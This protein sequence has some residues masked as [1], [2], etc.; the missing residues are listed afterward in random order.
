M[1]KFYRNQNGSNHEK[2]VELPTTA[3]ETYKQGEALVLS[4]GALTKCG[5]TT[6]P[7]HIAGRDYAAPATGNKPLP[8][9]EI[10]EGYEL[11]TTL[12]AAGTSLNIGD[13]VTLHTDGLQVTATTSSGVAEIV[14]LIETAVGG[15]VIVK[16]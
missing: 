4:S 5:A 3:S 9:Y 10:F 14:N 7:T 2:Y 15:R 12:Q 6:K 11:E 13:K 16:F 1:F 8:C